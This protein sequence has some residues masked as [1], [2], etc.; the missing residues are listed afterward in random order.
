MSRQGLMKKKRDIVCGIKQMSEKYI[1]ADV[2]K[3]SYKKTPGI[4]VPFDTVLD[5]SSTVIKT[6][7]VGEKSTEAKPSLAARRAVSL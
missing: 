1:T 5:T 4:S 7:Q 6:T 2:L 3:S